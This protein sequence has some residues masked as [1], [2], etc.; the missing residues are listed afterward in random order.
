MRLQ[1]TDYSG[2]QITRRTIAPEIL[3]NLRRARGLLFFVDESAF[4]DLLSNSGVACGITATGHKDAADLAARYTRILQRYFEVNKDALHLPVA[5]VV[6]KA[7]LLM[8]GTTCFRSTPRSSYPRKRKWNWSTRDYRCKRMRRTL[9][10]GCGVVYTITL[11]SVGIAKISALVFELIEQ[12]K[13][14]IAAAMC[15]TYRFQI[16]LISSLVFK[17]ENGQSFP[18]GVWDVITW[19]FNQLDPVYRLQANESIERACRELE[20]MRILL[21]TSIFRDHEAHTAY[22]TA[23]AQLKQVMT[24]MRVNILER[25]LQNRIEHASQRMQAALGDALALAELPAISDTT[26][27]APFILRRRVS[28]RDTCSTGIPDHVLEAVA[29]A[30]L[31]YSQKRPGM[32]GEAQE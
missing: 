14:F 26:D 17:N 25:F 8:G 5:L 4:P 20:E 11:Q 27:P 18:Y 3:R 9:F 2:A 28:R 1:F 23:V 22:L 32:S 13:G 31:W 6:N 30:A 7:D 12:F 29:R 16:F 10:R 15:H 19:M 24:K 21:S